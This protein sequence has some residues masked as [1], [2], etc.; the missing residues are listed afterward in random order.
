MDTIRVN[1]SVFKEHLNREPTR[2][3]DMLENTDGDYVVWTEEGL[4]IVSILDND[5]DKADFDAN[6]LS[7]IQAVIKRDDWGNP[8]TAPTIES[9]MGLYPKKKMYSSAVS[10]PGINIFDNVVTTQRRIV[11]GEYWIDT[12]QTNN[13]HDL[14]NI[15]FSVVD[16]NDVLGLFPLYGLTVGSDILELCKFILTD[17]VKKGNASNGF[18]TQLYAGVKGTNLVYPG[19]FLRVTYDSYNNM[20]VT[21]KWRLAYYE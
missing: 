12:N 17:Y 13:V 7:G 2:P 19:L 8:I 10:T 3:Y 6:Y 16:K 15:E 20:P 1:W 21:L 4:P 5:V 9:V 18:H 11:G 14:D